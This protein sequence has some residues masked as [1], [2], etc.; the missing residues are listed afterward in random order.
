MLVKSETNWRTRDRQLENQESMIG[1]LTRQTNLDVRGRKI[2]SG[3]HNVQNSTQKM[4]GIL[5]RLYEIEAFKNV[6]ELPGIAFISN[7]QV[8]VDVTRHDDRTTVRHQ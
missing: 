4:C 5:D 8:N 7:I 1:I 2:R 6:I 3:D